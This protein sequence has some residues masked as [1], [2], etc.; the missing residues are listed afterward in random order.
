[1][2]STSNTM[3]TKYQERQT[4]EV[5]LVLLIYLCLIS[6]MFSISFRLKPKHANAKAQKHVFVAELKNVP[7]TVKTDFKIATI[8]MRSKASSDGK[9]LHNVLRHSA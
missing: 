6:M 8:S 5:N 3:N 2:K 9:G 1:M 7:Q 4:F